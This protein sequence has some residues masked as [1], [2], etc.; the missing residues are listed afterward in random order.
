MNILKQAREWAIANHPNA[1]TEQHAAFANSVSYLMSGESCGDGSGPSARE[2]AVSHSLAGP[3]GGKTS[4]GGWGLTIL[5]PDGSLPPAGTWALEE[6]LKFAEPICFGPIT[7]LHFEC[8]R[9]E[10]CFDDAPEDLQA[11]RTFRE[12]A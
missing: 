10:K 7:R 8:Y 11:L 6:A 4:I 5:L 3:N 1:P 12:E 2:H 9:T